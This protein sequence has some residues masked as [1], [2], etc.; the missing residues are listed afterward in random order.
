MAESFLDEAAGVLE[1]TPAVL[2]AL[3]RGLPE[4]WTHATEGP[5]TWS[6]YDVLGHL[7]HAERTD[8]M[9]RLFVILEHGAARPFD[10]FDREAQFQ[11]ASNRSI[12]DL[13][14]DFR[15]LRAANL[16]RLRQIG[17]TREHLDLQGT[18]PTLGAVTVRQLLA[19][20][21]AHDLAH[22]VQISRTMAKRYR[23][24]VGPWAE[25]LSVMK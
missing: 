17:L 2:N 6:P 11:E 14:D 5:G 25:Y 20:W 3:L 23:S 18:H 24:E 10:P 1:R 19:T 13:L 22:I 21:T 15:R 8:W 4:A 7:N 16:E 12:D 9:T